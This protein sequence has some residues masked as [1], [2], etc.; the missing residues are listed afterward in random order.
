[1]IRKQQGFTL[2]ELMIVVA[3]IGILA[4]VAIP[5]YSD[6]TI[7]AKLSEVIGFASADKNA[8]A[9]FYQSKG[10]FGSG[11]LASYG[12]LRTRNSKYLTGGTTGGA[13]GVID[14]GYTAGTG[15]GMSYLLSS[16][17]LGTAVSTNLSYL[18]SV[19]ADGAIYW[20]C[21]AAATAGAG[22][23]TSA[24]GKYLPAECR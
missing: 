4:A 22:T 13:A 2:I 15:V 24:P 6:Y 12:V 21:S 11:G 14:M 17:G 3:I 16:V 20:A 8:V 10:Y 9:E 7:R 23:P 5:A 19:R 1:M 18:G